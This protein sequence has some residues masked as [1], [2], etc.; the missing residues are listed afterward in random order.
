MEKRAIIQ[1]ETPKAIGERIAMLRHENGWTQKEL[2]EKIGATRSSIAGWEK[3]CRMPDV[4]SWFNLALV[5]GVST[6]YIGGTSMQRVFKGSSIS[7]KI[8][9]DKLNDLGRHMLYE[10]YHILLDNSA[11][12]KTYKENK[13]ISGSMEKRK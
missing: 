2:A 9:I 13:N 8:D 12:C 10:F 7:D 5:F 1:R 4:E 6:D 11:F 3:G